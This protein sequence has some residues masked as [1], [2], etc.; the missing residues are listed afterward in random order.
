MIT[1]YLNRERCEI[2]SDWKLSDLIENTIDDCRSFAVALNNQF[3]PRTQYANCNLKP[4]D[5]IDLITA[6]AGG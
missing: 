2:P 3:I 1:V 5:R 4:D 6:M